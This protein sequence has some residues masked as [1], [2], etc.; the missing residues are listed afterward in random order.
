[1]IDYEHQFIF[2]LLLTLVVEIP[3]LLVVVRLLLKRE[4]ERLPVAL[5]LFAGFFATFATL[6]YVWFLFPFFIRVHIPYVIASEM[7]ALIMEALFYLF[8]LRI[9]L[10]KAFLLSLFCNAASFLIGE[11][12]KFFISLLS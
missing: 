3:V 4:K 2:S 10:K 11:L 7:F 12:V 1:M 5:L 8:I 6:P 9:S